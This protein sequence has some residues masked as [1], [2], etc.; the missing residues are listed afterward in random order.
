MAGGRGGFWL[1]KIYLIKV[2]LPRKANFDCTSAVLWNEVAKVVTAS[3]RVFQLK[4]FQTTNRVD[5]IEKYFTTAASRGVS[6]RPACLYLLGNEI[7]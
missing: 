6:K 7:L 2:E 4:Y 3:N 5:G 1:N